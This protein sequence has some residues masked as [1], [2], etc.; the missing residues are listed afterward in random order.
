MLLAFLENSVYVKTMQQ[1]VILYVNIHRDGFKTQVITSTC[2]T[3]M[4]KGAGT[5]SLGCLMH[6]RMLSLPGLH[7]TICQENDSSS[8][9]TIK[10]PHNF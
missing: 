3:D 1:C 4:R 7:P 8:L 5:H 10:Y 9:V 6:C 2:F